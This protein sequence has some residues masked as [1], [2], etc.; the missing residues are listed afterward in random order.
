MRYAHFALTASVAIAAC[1]SQPVPAQT[2]QAPITGARTAAA[3]PFTETPVAT[4]NQPWA[5][6]FL[7]GGQILV[8]E[9]TGV[10]RLVD[11]DGKASVAISGTPAVDSAGQGGLMDVVLHPNFARNG[12]VYLSWSETGD[13]GKGVALGRGKL[14]M[15]QV[16]CIRAPC[17]SQARLEGFETIFR[18]RPFVQGNGHY[19]G[20]IAFSPDGKYLFFTNGERQKFAPAQDKVMTLGKVLRLTPDGKPAP[21]NP[22]VAQ[23]Y[24]PE[25]WSY[26]HRNLL[27]ITFDNKGRLWEQE[28]GPKGGDEV[29]MILP[30]RNYGYPIVSNGDHYD[31]EK[32]ADHNIPDHP[33]RPEFEAPKVSWNPVISPAGLLYYTGAMFPGWTGNLFI[34]G[35]SSQSLIRV[36]IT[37]DKAEEAERYAM[38]ARIRE[39]EQGPDGALWVLEDA[40]NGRLVKLTPR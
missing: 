26:G 8:T 28:M 3:K 20:R 5:M 30:G 31:N 29:N 25:V 18:A 37:G 32:V 12:I 34:G 36:K 6:T 13:G 14:V 16:Q 23:G 4:F 1:S 21:G 24:L 38:G 9:K 22:L 7:P 2:G 39:V 27:G 33:T 17:P 11:G 15:Q 35:L 19:S 40:S 10:L